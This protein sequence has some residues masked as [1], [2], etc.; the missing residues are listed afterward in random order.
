MASDNSMEE[1]AMMEA[2]EEY[3][4]VGAIQAAEPDIIFVVDRYLHVP[5]PDTEIYGIV[6]AV[7]SAESLLNKSIVRV[8]KVLN[9]QGKVVKAPDYLMP[10]NND[11]TC[12]CYL[13]RRFWEMWLR[14]SSPLM[15]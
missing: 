9:A 11:E 14:P 12:G 5:K 3:R 10:S 15:R 13:D 7:V 2:G 8:E 6:L 1:N 4:V